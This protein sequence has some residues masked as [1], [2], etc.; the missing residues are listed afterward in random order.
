MKAKIVIWA[1]VFVLIGC[2]GS[3]EEPIDPI[4]GLWKLYSIESLGQDF[5]NDCK[6]KDQVEIRSDKTFTITIHNED[7]SCA[8]Q[9]STGTW[10]YVS[11]NRYEFNADGDTRVFTLL[12]DSTLSF[13]F[14]LS[15]G[16]V[17][18]TYKKE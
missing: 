10:R 2:S 14:N 12:S 11:G 17:L 18:Y 16:A 5:I 3:K 7:S 15:S 8:V 6:S 1:V 13:S 9:A 4:V